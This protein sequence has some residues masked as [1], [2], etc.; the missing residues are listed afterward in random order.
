MP[1]DNQ[2][3]RSPWQRHVDAGHVGNGTS[4][5]SPNGIDVFEECPQCQLCWKLPT[6]LDRDQYPTTIHKYPMTK[7]V[8]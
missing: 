7:G 4:H 1:I 6:V 2:R 8:A 3:F 5:Y